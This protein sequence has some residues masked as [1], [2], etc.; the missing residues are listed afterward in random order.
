MKYARTVVSI[1]SYYEKQ[2]N[3]V[4]IVTDDFGGGYELGKYLISCGHKRLRCL[5]T[6]TIR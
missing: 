3:F 6:T 2:D 1:D 5:L 4:N